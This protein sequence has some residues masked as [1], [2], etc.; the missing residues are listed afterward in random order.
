LGVADAGGHVVLYSQGDFKIARVVRL[1]PELRGLRIL[2]SPTHCHAALLSSEFPP[3]PTVFVVDLRRCPGSR[4]PVTFAGR[5]AAWSP[6][7]TRLAVA[8]RERIVVHPAFRKKQAV[9]LDLIAS[10]LAWKF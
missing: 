4:A 6:D 3:T 1:R 7:G 2:F 5:A 10:D 9:T 8:E